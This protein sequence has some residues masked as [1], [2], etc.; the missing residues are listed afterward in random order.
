MSIRRADGV[1][2]VKGDFESATASC[3]TGLEGGGAGNEAFAARGMRVLAVGTGTTPQEDQLA[4]MG[5]IGLADPPRLEATAAARVAM[6]NH[7]R[8]VLA[9][10]TRT[11]TAQ[12]RTQTHLTELADAALTASAGR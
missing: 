12:K 3:R 4:L 6:R 10:T 9:E 2:Y 8:T 7:N 11:T 5:L 1:L